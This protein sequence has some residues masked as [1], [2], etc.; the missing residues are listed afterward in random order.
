MKALLLQLAAQAFKSGV[1]AIRKANA[2]AK[3][4]HE[5]VS[6][7]NDIRRGIVS[8]DELAAAKG[9]ERLKRTNRKSRTVGGEG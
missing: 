7:Y 9:F 1:A 8:G 5:R 3:R 4:K 6:A 2:A